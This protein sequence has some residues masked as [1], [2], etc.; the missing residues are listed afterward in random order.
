MPNGPKHLDM[1]LSR[2]K[3]EELSYMIYCERCKNLLN[4]LLK[5][6]AFLK[7][8][9]DEV[10]LVGGSTRIPAVQKTC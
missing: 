8:E 2:A 1:T 4:K 7:I 9:I 6:P 5:M 3:F 10:V